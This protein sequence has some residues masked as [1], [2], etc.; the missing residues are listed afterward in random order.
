VSRPGV[1]S[2]TQL[3]LLSLFSDCAEHSG[4][5]VGGSATLTWALRWGYIA[6]R[7]GHYAITGEGLRVAASLGFVAQSRVPV[8]TRD[9]AGEARHDIE[10][11]GG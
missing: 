7:P 6:G 2:A 10:K 9:G 5:D 3:D 11:E 8:E 1:L 4:F